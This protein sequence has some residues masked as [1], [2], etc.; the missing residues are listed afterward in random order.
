MFDP[1]TAALIRAAPPLE[2][3]DL[4]NL[5]KR[6]TEAFADIVSARIRLRGATAEADDEAFLATVAEL[7]RIA[8]AY[9]T[10]AALL[11][12]RE[13]RASAA[14]VAASAHQ[15]VS[16]ALRGDHA[17][18]QV[19]TA[20]VSSDVCATLLFLLAEAHADAAEAA[21]R[22]VPAPDAG[23]IERDL[24]RA[25]RNLA[26]GRLGEIVGTDE[27]EIDVNGDDLGFRALDALRLLLLRGITNLARQLRLR[28]DVAPEVGGV[29]P[30]SELFVQVRALASEPIDG[31][32]V[33]G[34]KLLSLYPGPLH[35]AN[36]LLGLEG[37]L[38]GTALS[39]IPTPGGVD[40]NGWW[41]T[42]RRMARQRPY[43]WRNHREAVA[44][45]YLEQGVSSAISFP[46]GGGKSTLAEL[47]I[48]TAL[49]RGERVIFLAP[50]HALVGQT[51]RSLKGTFQDYSILADV[52]EDVGIGDVVVLGEVT[53]MTPERCLMLLSVDPDAFTDLGLIV[54]DECHLLHS[55]EDDRSR[56]GLDA[57]LAVLNLTRLAPHADL[58][59]LSAMMKNTQEVAGWIQ[60][61]TGR[62]CLTLDLSWKPTRQVRGC[63][64]YPAEQIKTLKAILAQARIDY[65]DHDNPPVSVKDALLAQPFGL[66][67][68]L[69]TWLTTDRSDY[70]LLQLLGDGR[71]LSAGRSRGGKWYLTPN[72]NET[73]SA[74][75]AAAAIA[76]MKTLVF[77]QT[78]VFC[79]SCVKDYPARVAASQITLT[80]EEKKWRTL[81][82]EE[83]GGAGYC[84]MKLAADGTLRTGT[85][86]H[87]ALLLREERELHESLFR[88]PDGIKVLFA[89]S[90]LA[91]GMNLPSEVVIISG[92]SRFDPQADKMQKLEAHEL[93]NAAGRAGRAGEGAQGFV[94]LVPSK[95]I[96]FDDQNNQINGHWMELQAIFEQA[97]QCL[98]IDDPLKVVLDRIHHG[99]TQTGASAYLL[100]KLP[101]AI[102]EAEHDP[103]VAFLSRSFA[104]Y[105]ALIAADAD[106]LS[107]RLASALAARATLELPESDRWIELVS[108]AT[109]LSVELLQQIAKRLDAGAFSGTA[110]EVVVA[111]LDWLDAHPSQL[112][113]VVRRESLDEMFGTPYKKLA[114][115]EARGKYTLFWLRKLWPIWMSGAPLCELEKAFLGRSTNL[116]Q[117]KNARQFVSRLVPDLAF[118]AG[119]PGRLL[120]ARLRAAG[121]ETPVA[122]VLATLS[123]VVR[124]GCDSPDSLAVRLHLT[125]SVSRVAARKH[126]DAIRQHIQPG[127]PDESF[128]DT[129]ERIR[130]ADI[131]AG[132]DDFDDLDGA[133]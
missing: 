119:L 86:S 133:G 87:H 44:K 84:Y 95:V 107:T 94:L 125:R 46:T 28:V 93:L 15:A 132:F 29:V 102:A 36:L 118:L 111:L 49:L 97:D 39:R 81:A 123:G 58:L 82:E 40:D 6:L 90:T 73:S 21:K 83:M 99:V 53:V 54:F 88:R 121:G 3:L 112:L 50:T 117:C 67:S 55:R 72:G 16:L 52:D 45:G 124:E 98:V 129:L 48:A 96:D 38:L 100:S 66:F 89:T 4:E 76:G 2:G 105:R 103:A 18:S 26:Q 7:R 75:A 106:W 91:Q 110:V 9:E 109:G 104:A 43:L 127:N 115:D 113:T 41:Q 78:T 33:A 23:P 120:A 56:R 57:M 71:L 30:A 47:K 31:A 79:E 27:P 126:F 19:D 70:S 92:D 14:F 11:P 69:Q 62:Q 114:D 25:I 108:G 22:I 131:V 20:V 77:V 61:I 64:V 65:P 128:E 24:L 122:T 116:K 63:V 74:I 42:L 68:L 8:A 80:E 5:P 51:Q 101:L 13:N 32:G 85:A 60:Y 12:D 17:P 34:E 37:D 130:K 10:Y 35:L 59:L 1:T